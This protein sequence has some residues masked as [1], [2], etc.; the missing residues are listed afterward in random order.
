V[1]VLLDTCTIAEVRKP[2]PDEAVVEV[3]RAIPDEQLF[4]SVLT[5]GEI[6]KGISLL[7]AGKRKTEL[8]AW[9]AGL[10]G[11][12]AERILPIDAETSRLWGELTARAQKKGHAIAA[13]DGLIAATALRHGLQVMTRNEKDFKA[14]G[15]RVLNPWQEA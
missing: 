5:V 10:E 2:K 4:L 13:V 8:A 11:Q 12:F 1:K 9:L 3:V 14:T 15:A 6:A 7:A